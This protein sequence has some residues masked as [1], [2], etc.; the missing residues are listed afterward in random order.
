MRKRFELKDFWNR[1][2]SRCGLGH[3]FC[4]YYKQDGEQSFYCY[5]I[6][7]EHRKCPFSDV[8]EAEEELE[9]G[10]VIVT[11]ATEKIYGKE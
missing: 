7:H 1:K 4:P 2:L 9:K 11:I 10:A 8:V 5:I 3:R 6:D